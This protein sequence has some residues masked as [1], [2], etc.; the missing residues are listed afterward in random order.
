MP[1]WVTNKMR[2]H[3]ED[4]HLLV[5]ENGE[6]DF[7]LIDPMPRSLDIGNI[8]DDASQFALDVYSGFATKMSQAPSV[9]T[10]FR[11]TYTDGKRGEVV[12]LVSPTLEDYREFGKI[13]SENKRLYGHFNWYSWCTEHWGTKWNAVESNVGPSDGDGWVILTFLT[14]WDSPSAT[15]M[16]KMMAECAHP[17]RF[18]CT[19]EGEAPAVYD[20]DHNK[21]PIDGSLF[22]LCYFNE[23]D[24]EISREDYEKT[25]AAGDWAFSSLV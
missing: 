19:F 6:V 8:C 4:L 15:M 24:E 7:N 10:E 20:I 9:Y 25:L 2:M 17:V 13:L 16:G 3:R 23:D 11:L 21:L 12:D 1:N 22:S 5:N 18:E 14:A